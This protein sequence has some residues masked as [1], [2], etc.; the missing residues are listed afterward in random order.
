MNKI[1]CT[2]Q[3]AEAKTLL[4]DVC[5]Y[6]HFGR[7]SPA[8]VYSAN[9]R[10]DSGVNW[11]IHVSSIVT[12]L[13]KTLFLA[14]NALN[15]RCV[16]VFDWL[17]ANASPTLHIA[18]SLTNVHPKRRIH[19]LLISSTPLL[20]NA[21]S[22]YDRPKQVCWVF[23]EFSRATAEFG[24][25]EASASFVSVLLFLCRRKKIRFWCLSPFSLILA[26]LN[27]KMC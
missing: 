17:W 25:P 16:V 19:C 1:P 8:A 4:V 21:T 2:S 22:I 10:F 6:G 13:H 27:C 24:R 18:F 15:R 11:W 9:C 12:Y 14:I 20:S 23:L 7:L 3:N 5:V 26:D